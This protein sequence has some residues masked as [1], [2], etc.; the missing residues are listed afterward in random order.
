MIEA[1]IVREVQVN[2]HLTSPV[3]YQCSATRS[4]KT[5]FNEQL[6]GL[7]LDAEDTIMEKAKKV[8]ALTKLTI[9]LFLKTQLFVD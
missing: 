5:T 1:I 9:S 2:G 6:P 4:F 8:L 3:W 7:I